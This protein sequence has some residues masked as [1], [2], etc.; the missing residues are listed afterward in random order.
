MLTQHVSPCLAVSPNR[1]SHDDT[2]LPYFC[3]AWEKLGLL[4]QGNGDQD[5]DSGPENKEKNQITNHK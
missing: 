2:Q 4:G 5:F 3:W 1:F